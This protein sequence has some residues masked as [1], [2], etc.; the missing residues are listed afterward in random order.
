MIYHDN[1]SQASVF[2]TVILSFI[3]S[4][5]IPVSF[6]SKESSDKEINVLQ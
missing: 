5:C 2:A 4:P 3:T 6:N 1:N